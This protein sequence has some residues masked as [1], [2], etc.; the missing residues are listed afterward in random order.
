[1]LEKKHESIGKDVDTKSSTS[2]RIDLELTNPW[3]ERISKLSD[4]ESKNY[5]VIR[6]FSGG[7]KD[8]QRYVEDVFNGKT[9]EY[10]EDYLVRSGKTIV[11]KLD[12]FE[13]DKKTKRELLSL[14]YNLMYNIVL[15]LRDVEV[16]LLLNEIHDGNPSE[17]RKKRVLFFEELTF[18]LYDP[19]CVKISKKKVK[20]EESEEKVK[21]PF[22]VIVPKYTPSSDPHGYDPNLKEKYPPSTFPFGDVQ[23]EDI[24]SRPVKV[25]RYD[26]PEWLLKERWKLTA[27][28]DPDYLAEILE[29][30]IFTILGP[31]MYL[32]M[33]HQRTLF[34]SDDALYDEVSL[35]NIFEFDGFKLVREFILGRI[36]KIHTIKSFLGID[37]DAWH[38]VYHV[39][40]D[41]NSTYAGKKLFVPFMV[42]EKLELAADILE[43]IVA[44]LYSYGQDQFVDIINKTLVAFLEKESKKL[45]KR[46]KDM[47]V[48][49][50]IIYSTQYLTYSDLKKYFRNRGVDVNSLDWVKRLMLRD[51][52]QL[53]NRYLGLVDLL[54]S[55]NSPYLGVK[56][57]FSDM[58]AVA[59]DTFNKNHAINQLKPSVFIPR[60]ARHIYK[61][62]TKL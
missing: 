50:D 48:P 2:K 57:N 15:D 32:T 46:M 23:G 42:Y 30:E 39:P 36:T 6:V 19:K 13:F 26:L 10:P 38:A 11:E 41:D 28:P 40:E 3:V 27:P 55:Y 22:V 33:E 29:D 37:P 61:Y 31:T 21:K 4:S 60:W 44:R 25:S 34:E 20:S 59:Y 18:M 58:V 51:V 14:Y 16:G 8:F 5:D 43:V 17:E 24:F 53:Q 49:D 12:R 54:K 62:I 7:M 9:S 47:G 1:M 56:E 45:E 52:I 35:P